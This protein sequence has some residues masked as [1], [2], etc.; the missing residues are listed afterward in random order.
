MTTIGDGDFL[1]RLSGLRSQSLNLFHDVH[2]LNDGTEDDVPVVQPGSLDGSDE[3]LGTVGVGSGVGHRHHTRSGVLQGEVLVLELVAVDGLATG[4]VVV[5]EVA[6]LAHEVGDD[7][8]EGGALVA[9]ALL[10]CAQSPEVFGG[11]WHHVAT[12]LK[13][14]T[15]N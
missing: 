8:V 12:Q 6:T 13:Q 7:T 4:A 3:E 10:A 1:R 5:G 2:A 15:H 9:E 11:L 14:L